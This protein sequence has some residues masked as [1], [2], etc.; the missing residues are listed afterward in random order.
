VR[1]WSEHLALHPGTVADSD[2][3]TVVDEHWR[4]VAAEQLARRE[5]GRPPTHRLLALPGVSR[6]SRR[7]LGPL[8]GLTDDG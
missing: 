7:L 6:R 1:L 5:D 3:V 2:P 4:P 8:E